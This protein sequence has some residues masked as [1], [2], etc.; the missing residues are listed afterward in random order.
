WA[1]CS[2]FQKLAERL[3]RE[4]KVMLLMLFALVEVVENL[5]LL[6]LWELVENL[7]KMILVEVVE[8]NLMLILVEV[9]EKNLMLILV[10]TVA[11]VVWGADDV[12]PAGVGADDV[13]PAAGVGADDVW[14]AG[15]GALHVVLLCP[16]WL[17]FEHLPSIPFLPQSSV[18][19]LFSSD[20][21]FLDLFGL[22]GALLNGGG[23]ISQWLE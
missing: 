16:V 10:E 22:P 15:V 3:L 17:H 6:V 9:V 1:S 19:D 23:S 18:S 4:T 13:W 12:W 11:C 20:A 7:M 21:L 8:K 5:M 14:P 2:Y